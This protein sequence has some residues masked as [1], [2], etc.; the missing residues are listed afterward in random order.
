MRPGTLNLI[1]DVPGLAIGHADDARLKSGVTVVVP[2][3]PAVASVMVLGG[4][5]GSRDTELLAPDQTVPAVDAIV[6]SGGSAFGLDAAGGVQARFAEIGRGFA[7]GP[8]VVPI[9]PGAILFD[10]LNGGDKAWGRFS[11]YRELGYQAATNLASGAFPL[12]TIGAGAGCSVSGPNGGAMKGGLGS[13]SAVLPN[14]I[15]VGAIVAVN[16][17]GAAT[18][19]DGPH[20]W[21]AA[22]EE[23][24]EFGGLGWPSPI[25]AEARAIRTKFGA[26]SSLANTTIGLVATDAA[27]TKAEARRLAV[28]AHDGFAR[29]LWPS[30]TPYD[31][32][33]IFALSTARQ[34]LGTAATDFLELGAAAAAVMARAVARGVYAATPADGDPWPAWGGAFGRG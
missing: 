1:T 3:Q 22:F 23:G 31:G 12:G 8:A 5:P 33:T 28:M 14:G 19:G 13:A 11:P 29:A 26:V 4:A 32:D 9:V 34:P 30:H 15:T 7:I 16:A 21:A 24:D 25:P 20:F 17:L 18:I 6:L 10:L 2:D 27:L